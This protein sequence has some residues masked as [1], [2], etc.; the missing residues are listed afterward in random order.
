M[1]SRIFGDL[2]QI[3]ISPDLRL[4]RS[5]VEMLRAVIR[6]ECQRL[7][8]TAHREGRDRLTPKEAAAWEQLQ[9]DYEALNG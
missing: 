5:T 1:A 4:A 7:L 6:M 9:E 8:Q 3:R 2:S